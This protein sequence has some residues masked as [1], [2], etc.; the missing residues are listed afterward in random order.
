MGGWRG[1]TRTGRGDLLCSD[2]ARLGGVHLGTHA[3][4]LALLFL[5]APLPALML[6]E[7][8]L[9]QPLGLLC[10]RADRVESRVKEKT[11]GE[12]GNGVFVYVRGAK[13]DEV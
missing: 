9:A 11:T 5:G 1:G 10:A 2:A 12:K 13:G 6:F 3:L 7:A 4:E 8:K